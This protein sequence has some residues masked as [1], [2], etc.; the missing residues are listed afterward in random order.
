MLETLGRPPEGARVFFYVYKIPKK[1]KKLTKHKAG[2]RRG[3][4]L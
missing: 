4:G 2:Q 1:E 3:E